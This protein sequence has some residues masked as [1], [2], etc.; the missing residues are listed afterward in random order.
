MNARE[1]AG[2]GLKNTTADAGRRSGAAMR[3]RSYSGTVSG[4]QD[5]GH[6]GNRP[7]A[8]HDAATDKLVSARRDPAEARRGHEEHAKAL[9]AASGSVVCAVCNCGV[10]LSESRGV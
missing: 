4:G 2:R 10:E 6:E 8:G 5:R 7:W 9:G 1:S 3:R